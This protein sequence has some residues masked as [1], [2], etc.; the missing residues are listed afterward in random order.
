MIKAGSSS[1]TA[2][3]T[4]DGF[5][6]LDRPQRPGK[7][8]AVVA[9]RSSPDDRRV[10]E[11]G[12]PAVIERRSPSN[13]GDPD[14][15]NPQIP[16]RQGSK[17]PLIGGRALDIR[18]RSKAEEALRPAEERYRL[19][20]EASHDVTFIAAMLRRAAARGPHRT[21][22][23]ARRRIESS[24]RASPRRPRWQWCSREPAPATPSGLPVPQPAISTGAR[25]T[26]KHDREESATKESPLD[27]AGAAQCGAHRHRQE[28]HG[29]SRQRYHRKGS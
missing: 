24:T 19:L 14:L 18:K 4:D 11:G 8:P 10:V 3:W 6:G 13:R 28:L 21:P 23:R 29:Q 22:R 1:R 12:R 20:A 27:D 9:A 16:R 5:A 25:I 15:R 2:T 26:L 7:S 17:P